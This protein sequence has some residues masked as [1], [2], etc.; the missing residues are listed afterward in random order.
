LSVPGAADAIHQVV[1]TWPDIEAHPHRFGGTEYRL[2]RR[3]IGHIHGD[4]LLDIPFPTKVRDEIVAAGRAQPHHMLAESGWVSFYLR[5]RSD[6]VEAIALL[7]KSYDLAISQR[8]KRK[9]PADDL[10]HDQPIRYGRRHHPSECITTPHCRPSGSWLLGILAEP[11][12][13]RDFYQR[14]SLDQCHNLAHP[15][16]HVCIFNPAAGD[17]R[18]KGI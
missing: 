7:R 18:D 1:M 17:N 12:A 8:A 13:D 4:Y 15:G 10:T 14:F 5:E 16:S 9:L 2:G 3:E 6:I 11:T